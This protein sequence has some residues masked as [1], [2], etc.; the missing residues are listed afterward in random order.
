[1]S[2]ASGT[3][4]PQT[5]LPQRHVDS[6]GGADPSVAPLDV[7]SPSMSV[8]PRSVSGRASLQQRQ[9]KLMRVAVAVSVVAHVAVFLAWLLWPQPT[10]A[11]I[12]LDEAVIKT[13]LVKLGKPR[14]E[15]LLPRLPTSP[16]PPPKLDKKPEPKV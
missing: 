3:G 14:D 13:R 6:T 2:P 5:G 8:P 11:A 9:N 1:M 12:D 7:S 15:K 10:L 4:G 16:P